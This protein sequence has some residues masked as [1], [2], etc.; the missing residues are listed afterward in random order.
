MNLLITGIAGFAGSHLADYIHDHH[1]EVKIFG[2]K[3]WRSSLE[4]IQH[5]LPHITLIDCDILDA[6]AC[7]KA[8]EQSQPAKIFHLAAQSFVPFSFD[9]PSITLQTNAIGTAN[10]LEAVKYCKDHVWPLIHICSSS[11]VY[12]Q[13]TE[14]PT[15][16]TAAL[17]P[18]SPY[19]VS[20]LAEERIA[21]TYHKAYGMQVVITRAFSHTGARQH[22]M[23]VASSIAKQ[24]AQNKP[25]IILGNDSVRTWCD[26]RDV[27]RA[28]WLLCD[29]K[30]VGQVYNVGGKER[31]SIRALA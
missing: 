29:K 1:P 20:K 18:I 26:V 5:L 17:N 10:L 30:H 23:L 3:R 6:H 8:V 7:I 4:N 12:G 24:I 15:P 19:G 16:E 28:Y 22:E 9:N 13:A 2:T 27:V 14:L 21:W 31:T 11:E 25:E